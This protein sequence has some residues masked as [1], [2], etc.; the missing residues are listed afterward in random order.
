MLALF[1]GPRCVLHV[2][3]RLILRAS[4][5]TS[6]HIFPWWTCAR[7]AMFVLFL[8]LCLNFSSR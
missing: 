1:P 2:F 8:A 4:M 5:C 7:T 6:T 3:F